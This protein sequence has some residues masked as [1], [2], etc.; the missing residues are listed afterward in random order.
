MSSKNLDIVVATYNRKDKIVEM[1]L[2]LKKEG[3]LFD[4]LIVVDSS[5]DVNPK[6]IDDDKITYLR[7]SH[8]N[9]PYQRFLGY[10]SSSSK[11]I[12]FLDDDMEPI[13]GWSKKV[14]ELIKVHSDKGLI[15]LAFEDKH[16]NSFLKK[17]P[18]SV[19]RK[20]NHFFITKLVKRWSGYPVLK[21][22]EYFKNGVKGHLPNESGWTEHCSGGAFIAQRK[23]LYRNFNMQLFEFYDRRMGKGEDGILS[24]TIS[25]TKP[26]YYCAEQLFWHND[27]GNSVYTKDH[28]R[29]NKIVAFSR[30]YLNL[31]YHRL[32]NLKWAR[33][34]YFNYGVWRLL[35]L[36]INYTL[37]PSRI[38]LKSL[39]GYFYGWK[40]GMTIKFDADLSRNS[41]W[42]KRALNDIYESTR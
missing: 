18:K 2:M 42:H 26:L 27:Q 16:A 12:L 32:N 15:G 39:I 40:L 4:K 21:P 11:W 31:E 8:K 13:G 22:G 17:S 28:F 6:L 19:L 1:I 23:Y 14:I 5:D 24:Y 34:N 30:A 9:Q 37:K 29:F 25:K 10:N 20:C 35:G 33:L 38:R 7:S 36:L 41:V 3:D